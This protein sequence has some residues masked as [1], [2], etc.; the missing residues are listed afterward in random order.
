MNSKKKS[1]KEF[2]PIPHSN[3]TKEQEKRNSEKSI[4]VGYATNSKEPKNQQRKRKKKRNSIRGME[5]E[6]PLPHKRQRA[7]SEAL[8]DGK[9]KNRSVS[10]SDNLETLLFIYFFFGRSLFI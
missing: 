5:K 7:A 3:Q 8:C 4:L 2:H 6:V 9:G 10:K 1:R